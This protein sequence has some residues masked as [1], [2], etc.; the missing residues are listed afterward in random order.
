[1]VYFI[2]DCLARVKYLINY[3]N[4]TDRNISRELIIPRI[5][6]FFRR[7]CQRRFAQCYLTYCM[8]AGVSARSAMQRY[9]L[10][11]CTFKGTGQYLFNGRLVR[12]CLPTTVRSAI[13]RNRAFVVVQRQRGSLL[14]K[15]R[16][17][18]F[19]T[20]SNTDWRNFYK[21][22]WPDPLHA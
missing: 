16:S 17:E 20:Q 13:V 21:F 6:Q 12:L 10:I 8:D 19:L 11:K 5:T 18:C 9:C 4:S 14:S 3:L 15:H 2:R 1:M 22:I 7:N